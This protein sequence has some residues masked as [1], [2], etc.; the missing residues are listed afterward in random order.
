MRG[1]RCHFRHEFRS[2]TKIHRHF[3]MAHFA[4]LRLT[5]EEILAESRL[6]PDG[7]DLDLN[8]LKE[9]GME[10]EEPVPKMPETVKEALSASGQRQRLNCFMA[11][12]TE[13][14]ASATRHVASETDATSNKSVLSE[15]EKF[16]EFDMDG[17]LEESFAQ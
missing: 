17:I 9:I 11:I 15:Q 4:A 1:E 14:C 7:D 16:A 6:Q 8:F 3:Y 2:F 5:A 10:D 13:E 12:A